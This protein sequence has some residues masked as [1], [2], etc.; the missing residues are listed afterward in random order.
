MSDR[1]AR[2][3]LQIVQSFADFIEREALPGTGVTA[4]V[5]WRGLSDLA[6]DFGPKNHKFLAQRDDLQSQIDS[7]HA[8]RKGQPHN[9]DD[10]MRFLRDIGYLVAE[11]PDFNIETTQVD[12]EIAH[13]SGPQLVVPITNA[14]FALNAVNARW[15]SLYDALY[16]TDV[17]GDLPGI[18]GYEAARGVRVIAWGRSFLDQSVPLAGASWAASTRIC[19]QDGGL[20]VDGFALADGTQL[21][22]YNGDQTAPTAIL[23]RNNSLHIIIDI[24]PSS[25]IGAV[26]T[27]GI[28][29]I[30][31][32]S[33][34]TTIMD[35]EDSV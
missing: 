29:D 15:G 35:C 34:L 25:A 21:I 30:R 16:G 26:D 31:L 19:L 23:L 18:G 17:L 10:Y 7:W 20:L 4:D 14:R 8:A 1:V 2:H 32:E 22:G 13:I 12:P 27:A 9:A 5:F 11:G 6:H 24:E 3:G 33:A 28:A